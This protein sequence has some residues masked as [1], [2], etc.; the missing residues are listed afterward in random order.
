[1]V[2]DDPG[3]EMSSSE[4]GDLGVPRRRESTLSRVEERL[5]VGRMLCV[6][7]EARRARG[8]AGEIASSTIGDGES[9]KVLVGGLG[10]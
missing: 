8:E 10:I 6:L 4:R 2:G 9:E 1:M 3:V 7:D 5:K